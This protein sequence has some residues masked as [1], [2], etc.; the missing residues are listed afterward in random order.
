MPCVRR[1]KNGEKGAVSADETE[2]PRSALLRLRWKC[3]TARLRLICSEAGLEVNF[4]RGYLVPIILS[5]WEFARARSNT[6]A[7]SIR[8]KGLA[9]KVLETWELLGDVAKASAELGMRRVQP[10]SEFGQLD[11]FSAGSRIAVG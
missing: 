3:G 2:N 11:E 4:F 1:V 10:A 6:S 9:G 7:Q 8:N 5:L